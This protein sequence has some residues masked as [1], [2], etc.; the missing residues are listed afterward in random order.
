MH[1]DFVVHALDAVDREGELLR[2]VPTDTVTD[3]AGER[4]LAGAHRDLDAVGAQVGAER[5]GGPDLR[6]QSR[7]DHILR[8]RDGVGCGCCRFRQRDLDD[9]ILMSHEFSGKIDEWGAMNHIVSADE[10]TLF[11]PRTLCASSIASARSAP[12]STLPESLTTPALV[13][14]AISEPFTLVEYR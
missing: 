1:H 5:E 6:L 3:V 7:V 4:R 12:L 10:S 8:R 2:Q 9:L 14:T 11:T 13:L